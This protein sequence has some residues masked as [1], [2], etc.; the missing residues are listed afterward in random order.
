MPSARTDQWFVHY[1]RGISHERQGEWDQAEADF[2]RA[3]ELNPDQ[4]QVL[5]YLGYSL[6]EQQRSSTRRSA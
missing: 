4:P 3:L 6:V 1:A 5:N 2:R